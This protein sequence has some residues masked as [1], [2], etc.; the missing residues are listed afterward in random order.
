MEKT[1]KLIIWLEIAS[2]ELAEMPEIAEKRKL[3]SLST[4]HRALRLEELLDANTRLSW[5]DKNGT[6]CRKTRRKETAAL[7]R[8]RKNEKVLGK[9]H[10]L[11]RKKKRNMHFC[12]KRPCQS[13]ILGYR[14]TAIGYTRVIGNSKRG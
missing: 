3:S 2:C 6:V 12:R 4:R 5:E 8:V 1:K 9:G 11:S 13:N 7:R 10:T 14:E